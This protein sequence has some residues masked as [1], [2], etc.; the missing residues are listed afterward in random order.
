MWCN[1]QKLSHKK[2]KVNTIKQI[3]QI[4]AHNKNVTEL[5]V[6]VNVIKPMLN[7]PSK[8]SCS[9]KFKSLIYCEVSNTFQIKHKL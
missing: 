8:I 7:N 6:P 4:L 1:K 9:I 5:S 2:Y 3:L